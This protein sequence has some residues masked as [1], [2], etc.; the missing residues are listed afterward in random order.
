MLAV[1]TV[2]LLLVQ[3]AARVGEGRWSCAAPAAGPEGR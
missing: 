2:P 3:D 1:R